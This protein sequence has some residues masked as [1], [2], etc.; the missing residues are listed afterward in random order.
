MYDRISF[1]GMPIKT[2]GSLGKIRVGRVTGNTHSFLFGL[3][4]NFN[5]KF[6]LVIKTS[7][8]D[9]FLKFLLDKLRSKTVRQEIIFHPVQ[10]TKILS[11]IDYQTSDFTH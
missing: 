2:L 4:Q 11:K 5:S 7:F 1:F 6:I 9:R 10:Q 3:M 8:V